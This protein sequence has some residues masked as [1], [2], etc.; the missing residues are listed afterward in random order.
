MRLTHIRNF[1]A[2]VEAGSMRGAAR[3]LRIA[4]PDL[5]RSMHELEEELALKLFDRSPHGVLPTQA[6][7]LFLARAR[8]IQN[9]LGWIK[10]EAAQLTE[11]SAR[12]RFGTGIFADALLPGAMATFRRQYPKAE[13]RILSGF[14]P[15]LVTQLREGLIEFAV[16]VLP[17]GGRKEKGIKVIPLF[18]NW[19]VIVGR[20]GHP[21]R[22]AATLDK[23]VD[24][25]WLVQTLPDMMAE[26]RPWWF[27][28]LFEKNH[29][30]PPKSVVRCDGNMFTRLL[31]A[32]DMIGVLPPHSI[33]FEL[34]VVDTFKANAYRPPSCMYTEYLVLRADNPLTPAAAAMLKAIR[35]EAHKLA[36]AKTGR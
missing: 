21:L 3:A 18:R 20:R 34:G 4:Q 26:P 30:A 19:R 24:A 5:T 6:G 31:L 14:S 8:T 7:K 32:T 29:L 16:T 28:D 25:D 12:I 15:L 17:P 1:L 9:E 11:G 27:T 10:E 35:F 22:N 33:L 23:L 2:T 36:F 13:V